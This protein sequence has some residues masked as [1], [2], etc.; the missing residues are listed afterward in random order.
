MSAPSVNLLPDSPIIFGDPQ[1]HTDGDVVG[2]AFAA[3]GSLWSVEEPGVVRHW[4]AATGRHLGHQQL[5]D[6]ET[7][8]AFS[9]DGRLLAAASND[10]AVWDAASGLLVG[11]LPQPSWVTALA[12]AGETGIVATGH[13][14]GRVLIWDAAAQAR[15]GKFAPHKLAV[16]SLAF[17][18]DGQKL[19]SACEDKTIVISRVKDG[20][21]LLSLTGHTDRIAQLL[22]HPDGRW[23]ISAGWDGMAR[24]WDAQSGEAVI[25]LNTHEGQVS[26]LAVSADGRFLA[27]A[28]SSGKVHVWS[29]P[30]IKR[31][32]LLATA[33]AEIRCLAFS[34]DGKCLASG[35]TDRHI[36]LWDVEQGQPLSAAS[37]L[38]QAR[39][40]V[41]LSADGSRLV[42]NSGGR[43]CR[44]WDAVARK[45]VLTLTDKEPIGAVACSP[46]G[47]WI[48][49]AAGVVVRL[50]DAGTGK[51]QASL[52]DHDAPITV[53]TFS[54]DSRL[55]AAASSEGMSVWLWDVAEAKPV[56]LIPDALDG[57]SVHALAFRP[58][59]VKK[60]VRPLLPERPEECFAQKGP[61]PFFDAA[62][63]QRKSKTKD[64]RSIIAAGGIDWMATGGSDGGLSFWDVEDRCE[65]ATF[66][67]GTSALAFH[68]SGNR[69]VSATLDFALVVWDA[70]T[71]DMI[72]EL[73]GH[74]GAI[75]CVAYSPDGRLLASGG[76]DRTVR[77][78]DAQSGAEVAVKE[79]DSQVKVLCFS[80]DGRHLFTGNGNTTCCRLRL[81]K[82]RTR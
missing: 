47:R 3:D 14:D 27:S 8:W 12:F 63:D 20:E 16:S 42:T 56:L 37:A 55:L 39:T 60:G 75:N 1:L 54:P 28:D 23:L 24:V 36:H 6:L 19:A 62:N 35:G 38:P 53:L 10:L 72:G 41:A 33:A 7:L 58:A 30:A 70:A 52:P 71:L 2:L 64:C 11:A 79:L 32:H 4:N 9:A 40:S 18:P 43:A 50:W 13:D 69:L 59:S 29:C 15:L 51:F 25:L 26:A 46:D 82:M 48:A 73:D 5:S 66:G 77:L 68:P 78:W 57:C 80:P 21:T 34:P 67:G 61:D 65:V 17:S 76:D 22:W 81:G 44:V 45:T 74:D 49:G 31:L